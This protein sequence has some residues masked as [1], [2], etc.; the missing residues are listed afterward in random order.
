[1]TRQPQAPHAP[2]LTPS[3]PPGAPAVRATAPAAHR[4]RA[5]ARLHSRHSRAA[6]ARRAP[7]FTPEPSRA[8]AAPRSAVPAQA[9]PAQAVPARYRGAGL[10]LILVA[11]F[12]VV[13]D[14]MCG[15]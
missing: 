9:V 7:V 4:R 2:A 1:M 3:R 15:S 5:T 10:A 11:S 8:A 12:M 13:L 14:S 6:T